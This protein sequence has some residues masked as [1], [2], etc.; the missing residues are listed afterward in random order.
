MRG[1]D[2]WDKFKREVQVLRQHLEKS[3]AHGYVCFPGSHMTNRRRPGKEI[4][5][6]TSGK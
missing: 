3:V 2:L 1:T 4:P 6:S 5:L